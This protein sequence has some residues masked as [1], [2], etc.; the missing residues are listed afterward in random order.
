MGQYD[1]DK[2]LA[3]LMGARDGQAVAQFVD[4]Y[5][6]RIH[7]LVRRYVSVEADAEDLT[8]EIFVDVYRAI[9]N[10]RGEAALGTWVYRIA[11][12]HCLK[13]CGR[14]ASRPDTVAYEDALHESFDPDSDPARHANRR[15]LGDQVRAALDTLSPLHR[16]VI[17]LHELHGL[18]YN[19]CATILQV[20]VGT[21]KS[22]LSNAFCRLR[23]R[24]GAYV[25]GAGGDAAAPA[26]ATLRPATAGAADPTFGELR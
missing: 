15:E 13:H 23:D 24:L 22:R 18:T 6:G 3:R 20:P 16:D 2:R 4:A 19:E 11:L 21:V 10:Y 26:P 25:L 12:N 8:Q 14:S 17:V 9:G 5:G 7:R 1:E